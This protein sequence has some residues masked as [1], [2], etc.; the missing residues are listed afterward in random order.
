MR[1]PPVTN[2]RLPS[3]RARCIIVQ[4]LLELLPVDLRY[5]HCLRVERVARESQ[6]LFDQLCAASHKL[7]VDALVDEVSRRRAAQLHKTDI[8]H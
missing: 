6:S 7:V 3:C 1:C 2:A 4:D 8:R 5:V